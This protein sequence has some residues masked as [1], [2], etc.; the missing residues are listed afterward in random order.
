[1]FLYDMILLDINWGTNIKRWIIYQGSA[2]AIAA[3][4]L[5]LIPL[6][7]RRQW[8]NLLGALIMG[9]LALYFVHYPDVLVN[10]GRSIY[11]IISGAVR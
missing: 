7:F 8:S 1:M 10:I 11:G 4:V 2:I 3:I 9:A 6:I 5:I